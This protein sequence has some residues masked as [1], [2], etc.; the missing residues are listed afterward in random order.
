M[1]SNDRLKIITPADV[2]KVLGVDDRRGRRILT[3]IR[4][5]LGK[6]QEQ[7]V[8]VLEFC[9]YTGHKWQDVV[10]CINGEIKPE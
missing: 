8:L 10:A 5:R 2:M 4:K 3:R 6:D 7:P 1:N 9:D